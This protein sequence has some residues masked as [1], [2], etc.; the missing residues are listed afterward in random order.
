MPKTSLTKQELLFVTEYMRNGGNTLLAGKTA[1]VKHPEVNSYAVLKRE[2]VKEAIAKTQVDARNLINGRAYEALQTM[3]EIMTDSNTPAAVR[4]TIAKNILDRA[5]YSTVKR[6]AIDVS[7][8]SIN[9]NRYIME[10][11]QRARTMKAAN[12]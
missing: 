10:I 2:R 5:G 11:V 4:F 12:K 6:A 7:S 1:G 9:E 3:I 8:S